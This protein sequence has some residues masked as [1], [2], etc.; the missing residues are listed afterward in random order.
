MLFI[1]DWFVLWAMTSLLSFG[2]RT[3][4]GCIRFVLLALGSQVSW[5]WFRDVDK[6]LHKVC[7]EGYLPR[8]LLVLFRTDRWPC[9]SNGW[10]LCMTIHISDWPK[11]TIYSHNS[12]IHAI[13][14]LPIHEQMQQTLRI[15]AD[16][17]DTR[18]F[19]QPAQWADWFKA[20][21]LISFQ[22]ASSSKHG[23][24]Q[25]IDKG[26]R[27]SVKHVQQFEICQHQMSYM[28]HIQTQAATHFLQ[29]LC[30]YSHAESY[31]ICN[32]I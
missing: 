31:A 22:W 15:Y 3:L 1:H 8:L 16:V 21:W 11:H 30:W 27:D 19:C 32:I 26:Y 2:L 24:T 13:V 9:K 14:T 12:T 17:E 10:Q 6:L 5:M 28:A 23:E 29:E 4:C 20:K 18:C 25:Q 7:T